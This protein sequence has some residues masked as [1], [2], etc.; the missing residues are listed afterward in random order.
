MKICYVGNSLC[1]IKKRQCQSSGS[2]SFSGRE[3]ECINVKQE[4]N[5]E[6][7][8]REEKKR[9]FCRFGLKR[10]FLATERDYFME[11]ASEL[12]TQGTEFL[13]YFPVWWFFFKS[14][15][16]YLI[17]AEILEHIIKSSIKYNRQ[18]SRLFRLWKI[19]NTVLV[20]TPCQL[21][22]PVSPGLQRGYIHCSAICFFQSTIYHKQRP[23]MSEYIDYALS[24]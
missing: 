14:H 21:G 9:V 20:L 11:V 18:P 3:K 7:A 13:L 23:Y 8:T 1:R 10:L 12:V 4:A 22:T 5:V 6:S 15:N 19:A 24:I 2:L 16:E 17:P